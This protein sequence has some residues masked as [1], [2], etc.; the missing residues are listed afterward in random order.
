MN[1]DT[2]TRPAPGVTALTARGI[3]V[4]YRDQRVI[5]GLDIDIPRGAVTSVIGPNGCG[6]S[7]LLKA[8]CRLLPLRAGE[9]TIDGT[10]LSRVPSRVLARRLGVLPQNPVAPEG[11]LVADLVVL[12]RHPHRSWIRQWAADDDDAVREALELTG[13]ADLADRAV[14]SLSGGQRQRVWLSMAL[15]QQTD[16][17]LLDEPTTYLDLAHSLD[18]LDLIDSMQADHG[19][20]VVMVLH[21]L[22]LACRYSDNLVVMRDGAVVAQG[23]P[24]DIVTEELLDS[25]FG[26]NARI[27]PDPVSD[28]P[29]IVP[30]G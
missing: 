14:D 22:A 27:L 24:A 7:T 30:V 16:I 4:G 23:D 3:D 19:R 18:V 1:T 17:L 6:K 20:T 28:R 10:P 29:L 25:V 9:V 2:H 11:V 15:A 12:G 13:V 8:L 5:S 21:D 26:L